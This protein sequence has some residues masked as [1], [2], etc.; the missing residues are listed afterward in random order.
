MRAHCVFN[1]NM[2]AVTGCVELFPFFW[3]GKILHCGDHSAA[4]WC[5]PTLS[6]YSLLFHTDSM[7]LWEDTVSHFTRHFKANQRRQL[8]PSEV[9]LFKF[10]INW[11]QSWT[12]AARRRW[13]SGLAMLSLFT[14]YAVTFL[15]IFCKK[16]FSGWSTHFNLQTIVAIGELFI[17][18]HFQ[19][20]SY[21]KK[22]SISIRQRIRGLIGIEPCTLS[23]SPRQPHLF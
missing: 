3:D 4:L 2:L 20:Y 17:I 14:E 7:Y 18:D 23:G 11:T 9:F 5:S 15:Y 6:L 8:S 21:F 12:A 19:V 10:L 16:P 13:R 22:G 1:G